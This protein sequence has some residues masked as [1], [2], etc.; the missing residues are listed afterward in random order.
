MA[1]SKSGL[2]FLTVEKIFLDTLAKSIEGAGTQKVALFTNTG[3]Y[4]E[5]NYDALTQY[6][7]S[8]WASANEVTATTGDGYTDAGDTLT[9]MALTVS[10][11]V[12]KF[13]AT[14][15]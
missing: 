5:A 13:D 4:A 11:G 3:D 10:T 15:V 8:Q 6:G 1:W 9:S 12:M 14:D 7:S 2:H